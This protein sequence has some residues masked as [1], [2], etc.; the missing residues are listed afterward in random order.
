[1]AAVLVG[2]GAVIICLGGSPVQACWREEK[3]IKNYSNLQYDTASVADPG[4]GAFLPPGS[5]IW[6][7]DE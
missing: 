3:I 7:K 1:M 4:S 5:G 6:I 2:F